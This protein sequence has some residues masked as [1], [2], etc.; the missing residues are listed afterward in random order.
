LLH[1]GGKYLSVDFPDVSSDGGDRRLVRQEIA[2]VEGKSVTIK[3][4]VDIDN[5]MAWKR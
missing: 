4:N 3:N 5:V 1:G 2:S